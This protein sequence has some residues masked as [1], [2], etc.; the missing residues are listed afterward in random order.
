MNVR[1]SILFEGRANI[2]FE[3]RANILFEKAAGYFHFGSV[4][5]RKF[6]LEEG[7]HVGRVKNFKNRNVRRT[8]FVNDPRTFANK[9]CRKPSERTFRFLHDVNERL[10]RCHS[11]GPKNKTHRSSKKGTACGRR[12]ALLGTKSKNPK[13]AQSCMLRIF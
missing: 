8:V 11:I 3:G 7:G 2:L 4:F 5:E 9:N 1:A 10:D 13:D 12:R 6:S